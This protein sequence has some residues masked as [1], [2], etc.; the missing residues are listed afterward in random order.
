MTVPA[1][2]LDAV[3]T[4]NLFSGYRQTF[5][6]VDRASEWSKLDLRGPLVS[7]YFSSGNG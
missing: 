5:A 2:Q 7:Q 1:G 6:D 3:T 4:V